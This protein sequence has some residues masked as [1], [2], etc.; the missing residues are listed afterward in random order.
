MHILFNDN[1]NSFTFTSFLYN[2]LS[3]KSK[4]CATIL[5]FHIFLW[6]FET[7]EFLFDKVYKQCKGRIWSSDDVLVVAIKRI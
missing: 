6:L 7:S 5:L 4:L 1:T 3:L 2:I